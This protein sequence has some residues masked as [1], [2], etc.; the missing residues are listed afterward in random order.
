MMT[1]LSICMFN[2]QK[3]PIWGNLKIRQNESLQNPPKPFPIFLKLSNKGL[4]LHKSFLPFPSPPKPNSQTKPKRRT[5]TDCRKV[6]RKLL[7][8]GRSESLYYCLRR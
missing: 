7:F 3:P 2:P 1:K 4:S 5:T 8:D 6:M